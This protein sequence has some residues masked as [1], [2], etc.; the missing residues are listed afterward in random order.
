MIRLSLGLTVLL[1]GATA[2]AA[3][4]APAPAAPAAPAAVAPTTPA[5]GELDGKRLFTTKTCVACHGRG[6]ARSILDYP[7]LAGQDAKYLVAQ[8]NDIAE[9]KRV[10]G[11][12]PRGYPRT[13]G[14]RDI[15]HLVSQAERVAIAD[16]LSKEPPAKIRPLDPPI[17]DARRAAGKEAF[18][19]GGCISC[20]GPDGMKPLSSYPFPAGQKRNYIALQLTEIRDGIRKNGR[21]RSMQP[22][23][24]KLDDA[25]I[26]LLADYLSQLERAPK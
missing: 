2:A 20:H 22:F 12:D 4:T 26:A 9:G 23:A 6:G 3:Q 19:K 10:A 14:M 21:V 24:K 15:M 8:M 16:Y 5:S 1:F 11:P 7:E 13:E 17:D 18:L 25:K